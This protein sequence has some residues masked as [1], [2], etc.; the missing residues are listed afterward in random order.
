MSASAITSAAVIVA[1]FDN[2]EAAGMASGAVMARI[3]GI[4]V[5]RI[6]PTGGEAARAESDWLPSDMVDPYFARLG[7]GRT[8]VG[9]EADASDAIAVEAILR[10]YRPVEAAV[11][12]GDAADELPPAVQSTAAQSGR[13]HGHRDPSA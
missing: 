9:V 4:I 12:G 8:L 1:L 3:P 7:E 11:H 10:E 13:P 5:H 2:A 6:D